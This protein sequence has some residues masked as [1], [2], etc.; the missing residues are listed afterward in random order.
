[1]TEPNSNDKRRTSRRDFLKT[2]AAAAVATTL[3]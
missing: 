1:M 3:A 2:S